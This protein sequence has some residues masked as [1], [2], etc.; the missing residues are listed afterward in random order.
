MFVFSGIRGEVVFEDA[1][2][3]GGIDVLVVGTI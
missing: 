2:D 3:R 1:G